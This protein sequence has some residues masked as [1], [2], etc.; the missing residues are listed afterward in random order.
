METETET[1]SVCGRGPPKVKLAP[2]K[3]RKCWRCYNSKKT[4]RQLKA[5]MPRHL[6][7]GAG[8]LTNKLS[9]DVISA[10]KREAKRRRLTTY[11][12]TNQ[13]LEAAAQ[14]WK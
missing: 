11:E 10:F 3:P 14:A 13:V 5:E 1:C 6:G 2:V 8:R 4:E 7:D 12:L 9:A